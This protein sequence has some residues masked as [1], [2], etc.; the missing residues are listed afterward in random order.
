LLW[1]KFGHILLEGRWRRDPRLEGK[2]KTILEVPWDG[3]KVSSDEGTSY[4]PAAILESS[5]QLDLEIPLQDAPWK[6][7]IWLAPI[8][9]GIQQASHELRSLVQPYINSLEKGHYFSESDQV[10]AKTNEAT[11]RLRDNLE[12]QSNEFLGRN[13]FVGVIGGD[14][15]VP[16]GFIK[17]LSSVHTD[18]GILQ[19]DAHMDLREAYEGFKHSHASIMRNA[20]KVEGVSKLVQVGIRD[21]CEEEVSFVRSLEGKV[22]VFYDEAMKSDQF[23]GMNWDAICTNIISQ[24]PQKVYVSFDIDGLAPELCT[25]TGTPVPGGL[26][27]DQAVYLLDKLRKSDKEV[28]GFDLCEVAPKDHDSGW[29]GNVGARILYRLCALAH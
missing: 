11:A 10:I 15:S 4:G 9:D 3:M 8:D 25:G 17:S 12:H 7:G 1:N 2:L 18:F 29:N 13:K 27:Y 28:I 19:I 23:Q 14:H 26:S 22:V 6:H 5:A 21:F 24:L 16:L 20:L